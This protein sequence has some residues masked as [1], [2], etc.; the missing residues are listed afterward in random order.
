VLDNSNYCF[1]VVGNSK[2][3]SYVIFKSV[4]VS[5]E[6]ISISILRSILKELI[7]VGFDLVL[8]AST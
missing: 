4:E 7:E 5:K 8:S 1:L 6:S 3:E 2:H